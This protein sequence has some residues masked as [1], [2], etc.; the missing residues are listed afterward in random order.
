MAP[1]E[2]VAGHRHSKHAHERWIAEGHFKSPQ[3]LP[4]DARVLLI[5]G[6]L[7]PGLCRALHAAE[8]EQRCDEERRDHQHGCG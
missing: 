7:L 8:K 6:L 3:D 4:R 1:V 2:D 5:R